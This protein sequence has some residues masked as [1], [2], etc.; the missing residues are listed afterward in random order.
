MKSE[1]IAKISI[2]V[3]VYNV[4]MYLNKCIESILKQTFKDFEL[5]LVNDGSTDSSGIICDEYMK[6]DQRIKVIHKENGGLSSA[7][8]AGIDIAIGDYIAFID[9]DDYIHPSMYEVLYREAIKE[10]SDIILCQFKKVLEKDCVNESHSLSSYEVINYTNIETLKKIYSNQGVEFIVAWNK[11]YHSSIFKSIRYPI[12]MIHEDEF[13]AHTALYNAKKVSYIPLE[14][15]YY[16]QR[17]NSIMQS[18]FHIN[19]LDV[20]Y[21]LENRMI[22]FSSLG[23]NELQQLACKSYIYITKNYY[24]KAKRECIHCEKELRKIIRHFRRNTF[25]WIKTPD[26]TVKEKILLLIFAIHPKLYEFYNI[27]KGNNLL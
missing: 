10:K 2:I 12:G 4:E 1:I 19:R 13:I 27:K 16:V 21:A 20:I 9:S 14:L 25:Y 24:F 6:K 18:K 11:L 7:R 5:I 15:Y 26:Y 22:F 3:P 8:N 23:L 17:T